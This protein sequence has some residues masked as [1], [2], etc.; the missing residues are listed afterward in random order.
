ME[1]G[2]Y[3]EYDYRSASQSIRRRPLLRRTRSRTRGAA[4]EMVRIVESDVHE[5]KG[6]VEVKLP[7][8]RDRFLIALDFE[9][10]RMRDDMVVAYDNLRSKGYWD[11]PDAP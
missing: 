8:E 1:V 3:S 7:M 2:R 5:I 10:Q 11:F 6:R 4:G 9:I